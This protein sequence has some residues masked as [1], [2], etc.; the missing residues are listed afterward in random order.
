MVADN[1]PDAVVDGILGT[2]RIAVDAVA[3]EAET[4]VGCAVVAD[5]MPQPWEA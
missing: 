5:A 3:V 1:T 4:L 2:A